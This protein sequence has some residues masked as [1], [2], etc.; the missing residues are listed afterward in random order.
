MGNF[1][2]RWQVIT[3]PLWR[4]L[5]ELKCHFYN[6]CTGIYLWGKEVIRSLYKDILPIYGNVYI[7]Y[8]YFWAFTNK[9]CN[10][11]LWITQGAKDIIL[12]H[13]WHVGFSLTF[14]KWLYCSV[15]DFSVSSVGILACTQWLSQTYPQIIIHARWSS[16]FGGGVL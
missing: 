3:V 4:L 12:F 5:S 2:V 8:A 7:R 14:S 13:D 15:Q 16:C 10:S 1:Y 11:I 9:A 6:E